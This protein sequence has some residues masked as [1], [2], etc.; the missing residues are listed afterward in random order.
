MTLTQLANI[1]E[2]VGGVAVLVTLVYLAVQVRANSRALQSAA[3]WNSETLFG[4]ANLGASQDPEYALLRQWIAAEMPWGQ[5]MR[6][7]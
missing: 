5:P 6:R 7:A 1:G 4:Q 3:A 2:F